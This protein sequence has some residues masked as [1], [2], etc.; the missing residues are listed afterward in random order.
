MKRLRIGYLLIAGLTLAAPL[1][2]YVTTRSLSAAGTVVQEKWKSGLN[3]PWQMGAVKGA[4]ITGTGDQA[5]IFRASFA[6]WQGL[7]TANI[8]FTEGSATNAR[9][10]YD[11][12]NL[13]TTSPTADEY[14]S[15]ALGLTIAYSF[16]HGGVHDEFGRTVDFPGQ[17]LEADI[18]FNPLAQ[19]S[20]SPVTPADKTDLQSVVTHEIGHFLGLDH[21]SL[22]SSV[23]FPSVTDGTS[24]ARVLS[25]DD[26]AG[27]S[28]IYP[29]AAFAAKGT[30][31]GVVR[32]TANATVYGAIVTAVNSNGQPVA[33]AI[34]DPTGRYTIAGLDSGSYTVYAEPLDQP[35]TAD[36]VSTLARI[37]PGQTVFT[38]FTTRFK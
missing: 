20:T 35:I 3:I 33:S 37:N 36:N 11:Q 19:F 28:T 12:I 1:W 21:T 14:S 25:A 9:P 22:L 24:Y 16:D 8:S 2:A 34:T 27:V 10:G 7:T 32:T 18:M 23:M 30:L 26:I 29:S 17:T 31:S 6:S 13:I 38:N 4:N 5:A 15:S